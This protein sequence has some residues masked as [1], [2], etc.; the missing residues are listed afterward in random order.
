MSWV[1]VADL[2]NM[3]EG[4]GVKLCRSGRVVAAFLTEGEVYAV[5]DLCSHAEASL[6]EGEV[7][8]T[9]VECPLHGAVF[10]LTSGEALTLPATRPVATYPTR[11]EQGKVWVDIPGDGSGNS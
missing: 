3:E 4:K 1:E 6:S 7:F 10:D 2:A 11:V 8:D 5:D 9:E